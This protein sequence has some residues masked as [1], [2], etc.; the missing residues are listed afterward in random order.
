MILNR[1]RR[2]NFVVTAHNNWTEEKLKQVIE[3]IESGKI[4]GSLVKVI[5][6]D[7]GEYLEL[8]GQDG[9]KIYG[10]FIADPEEES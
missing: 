3:D 10:T 1:E 8:T 2:K 4:K 7:D 9:S 6:T 5:N